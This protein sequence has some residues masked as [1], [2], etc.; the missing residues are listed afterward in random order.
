M[1]C[2]DLHLLLDWPDLCQPCAL[3]HVEDDDADEPRGLVRTV[4][5]VLDTTA[6]YTLRRQRTAVAVGIRLNRATVHR[7]QRVAAASAPS[8]DTTPILATLDVARLVRSEGTGA[9][10]AWW[11]VGASAASDAGTAV[12][13]DQ[14]SQR[15]EPALREHVSVRGT[16]SAE[17]KRG[18]CDDGLSE[19]D[20]EEP[21][22]RTVPRVQSLLAG[23]PVRGGNRQRAGAASMPASESPSLYAPTT[24]TG[25]A[26]PTGTPLPSGDDLPRAGTIRTIMLPFVERLPT[27]TFCTLTRRVWRRIEDVSAPR[28]VPYMGGVTGA[29]AESAWR[30]R[31]D[32][33]AGV[34]DSDS[35]ISE[36]DAADRGVGYYGL[37]A[38]TRRMAERAG[39]PAVVSMLGDDQTV[40]DALAR[41]L[42]QP[43]ARVRRQIDL[44]DRRARQH[45]AARKRRIERAARQSAL[46][47]LTGVASFA[48]VLA[49]G[50]ARA[51]PRASPRSASGSRHSDTAAAPPAAFVGNWGQMG[52]AVDAVC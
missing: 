52:S 7:Q 44:V 12:C 38:R 26:V 37:S 46:E 40:V 50:A 32:R 39:M 36:E 45:A 29:F 5:D 1:E 34:V 48:V 30:A 51:R 41:G 16:D 22:L 14:W 42:G 20:P 15:G 28:F 18:S 6:R 43:S 8:G 21:S 13:S 9:Y 24:T 3:T 2:S 23:T 10:D 11:V 31:L 4:A 17:G 35:D 49:S 27:H 47:R 19:S 25:F 33:W